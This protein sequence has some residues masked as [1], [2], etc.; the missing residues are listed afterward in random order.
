MNGN[1]YHITKIYDFLV[2]FSWKRGT[3]NT[4]IK[5]VNVTNTDNCTT[6]DDDDDDAYGWTF[7]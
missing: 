3:K 2:T 6:N 5:L 4:K 7:Y 1:H